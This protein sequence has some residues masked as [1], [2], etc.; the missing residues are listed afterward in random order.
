METK[1]CG[2]CDAEGRTWEENEEEELWGRHR[3]A[4]MIGS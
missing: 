1:D 2:V 4:V 3:L